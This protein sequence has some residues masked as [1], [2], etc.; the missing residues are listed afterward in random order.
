MCRALAV[1]ILRST[2]ITYIDSSRRVYN[3]ETV[4]NEEHSESIDASIRMSSMHVLGF[5]ISNHDSQLDMACIVN[6]KGKASERIGAQE[7]LT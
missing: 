2:H 1:S 3:A 5:D 7:H 6:I 4:N